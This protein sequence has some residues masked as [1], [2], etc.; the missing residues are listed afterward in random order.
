MLEFR[1][2][3]RRDLEGIFE[4]VRSDILMLHVSRATPALLEN[5]LV[6]LYGQKLPLKQLASLSAPDARTLVVQP[7]DQS[8]IG[9]I[10]KA[11]E[12]T[13]TGMSMAA[14]EKFLR[15]TMPQL[16]LERRVEM[17][18]ALG[19]KIEE[20]KIAIRHVRDKVQKSFEEAHRAK[21]MSEDEKFRSKEALQ[22]LVDEYTKKFKELED[23][24]TSEINQA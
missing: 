11:I 7:W 17:I 24:K 3:T 14:E 22:K 8:S 19:K 20:G 2:S 18:K 15:L 5:I 23:Q 4:R 12:N 13:H 6:S 16:S 21:K 9:E 1:D 10:Q